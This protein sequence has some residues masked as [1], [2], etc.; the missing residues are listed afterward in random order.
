ML[1]LDTRKALLCDAD[2]LQQH[3]VYE[4]GLAD[5]V[6]RA[7]ETRLPH[8][9]A[10][11][12]DRVRPWDAVVVRDEE[13]A[14]CG[15]DPEY[16]KEIVRDNAGADLLHAAA[17]AY[18]NERRR[19]IGRDAGERRPAIA[20]RGVVGP[21]AR[22]AVRRSHVARVAF[23]VQPAHGSRVRYPGWRTE[24]QRIDH[25]EDRRRAADTEGERRDCGR[26]EGGLL[27][28]HTER[29]TY[30][31]KHALDHRLPAD[32]ANAILHGLNAADLDAGGADGGVAAHAAGH[33]SFDRRLQV[34]PQF[35][36]QVLFRAILLEQ[37]AEPADDAAEDGHHNSPNDALRIL[38]IAAVW[39]SQS[40][41]SFLNRARPCA[42]I[43]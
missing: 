3:A 34:L 29:K 7:A 5:R 38:E 23:D 35:V 12:G 28:Q 18:I 24:E 37:P 31:L 11:D 30:V 32:V 41:A 19:Q 33:F 15:T 43:L 22:P 16:V 36:V 21:R 17:A 2:N 26:G 42:V 8:P 40:R 20:H 6:G 39:T 25:A 10:D 9:V 4:Q 1:R 14:E 13:P 27:A